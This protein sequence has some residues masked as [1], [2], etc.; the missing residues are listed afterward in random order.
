MSHTEVS[1]LAESPPDLKSIRDGMEEPEAA[2]LVVRNQSRRSSRSESQN[3]EAPTSRD[4]QDQSGNEGC[5]SHIE[6][7]KATLTLVFPRKRKAQK[8]RNQI[9]KFL[10]TQS[11]LTT[12]LKLSN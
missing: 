7:K 9:A 3:V 5:G 12:I 4:S 11:A 2:G 8:G 10:K 6:I 1:V